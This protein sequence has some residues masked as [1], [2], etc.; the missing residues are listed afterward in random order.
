[1][2]TAA[3]A[4]TPLPEM[5]PSLTTGMVVVAEVS[6][7]AIVVVFPEGQLVI[8]TVVVGAM[9][10]VSLVATLLLVMELSA[11]EVVDSTDE[12]LT[13]EEEEAE[14]EAEAETEA[15]ER[16]SL[17]LN[18]VAIDATACLAA[19]TSLHLL[20]RQESRVLLCLEIMH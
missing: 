8:A 20:E 2:A 18:S 9:V 6:I 16:S 19:S 3:T 11:T 1:M 12:L 10:V 15:D 14:A 13:V 5:Q 4:A 7:G 17:T